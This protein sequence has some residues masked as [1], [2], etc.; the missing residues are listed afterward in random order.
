MDYDSLSIATRYYPINI[1]NNVRKCA[2][3][4]RLIPYT[5]ISKSR[6]IQ[7]NVDASILIEMIHRQKTKATIVAVAAHKMFIPVQSQHT[8]T[9]QHK[10]NEWNE[11]RWDK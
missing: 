1:E 5:W 4:Q 7:I 3:I 9:A 6:S 8:H 10:G 2:T 11:N